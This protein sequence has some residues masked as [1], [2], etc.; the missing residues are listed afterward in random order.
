MLGVRGCKGRFFLIGDEDGVRWPRHLEVEC[1]TCQ[2]VQS[3]CHG[4]VDQVFDYGFGASRAGVVVC[5][6]GEGVEHG[7]A[8][9]EGF[10]E[11]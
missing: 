7:A 11:D 1:C 6:V 5:V 2:N 9:G 10:G 4:P 8:L 3:G